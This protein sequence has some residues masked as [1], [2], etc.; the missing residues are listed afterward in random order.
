[1]EGR[2]SNQGFTLT[3]LVVGL[4]LLAIVV[5]LGA[6]SYR[7]MIQ[8]S[9]ISTSTNELVAHLN[10]ARG[11][12]ISR[13]VAI[14]MCR[15]TNVNTASPTDSTCGGGTV[16]TWTTGWLMYTNPGFTGSGGGIDYVKATDEL[17][18][19]HQ[20]FDKVQIMS[21]DDGDKWLALNADG[22]LSENGAARFSICDDRSFS[23]GRLIEISMT[24]RVRVTNTTSAG[25]TDCDPT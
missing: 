9:E 15:S 23:T 14:I 24:G 18:A 22:S 12:A 16:E 19:F 17:L 13:N 4:A 10:R 25:A 11:E 1:M 7:T 21:D 20:G 8:N 3:E 6:P 2:H 5:S